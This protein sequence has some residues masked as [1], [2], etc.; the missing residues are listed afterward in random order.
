[1][2]TRITMLKLLIASC[3]AFVTTAVFGQTTFT[4]TNS[5]GGDLAV[6]NNWDPNGLPSGATQ[7]TAQ[8][9]GVATGN[10]TITYGNTSL[11]STGYGSSGINLVLTANQTGSVK[12][13]SSVSVSQGVGV[14]NI[15]VNNGAGAFSLGDG[16]ANNLKVFGRPAGGIHT[17]ENDSTNP[18]TIDSSVEFQAGGGN[19]YTYDFYGP[20]D[21]IVNSYL[22]PDNGA[23]SGT[24]I[25]IEGPGSVIW[26]A[27]RIIPNS[28]VG[29]ITIS[30]GALV[31][32]SSG[33]VPNQTIDVEGTLEYDAAAQSQTFSGTIVGA[34]LLEVNDGTLTLSAQNTYVGNTALSGGELV[35]NGAENAGSS[36]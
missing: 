5:A 11:P 32:K 3:C 23:F 25:L 31:I 10:L 20:G 35:V 16:S 12:I 14:N 28:P 34:G 13:V 36:G 4:W 21:W 1:M 24:T 17:F 8:W 26:S 18:A 29:G 2:K 7:D 27:G 22:Y 19:G 6:S 30:G 15:T 33:V 9:D